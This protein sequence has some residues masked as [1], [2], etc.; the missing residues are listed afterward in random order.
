MDRIE[1]CISFIVGKTAQQVTRRARELLAPFG[2]TPVQY[3]VLKVV[4][5]A[6][7][8]S[9]VDIGKRMVLDSASITGVLDRLESIGLVER[10]PNPGDRRAHLI[11][12][13]KRAKQLM[14]QLDQ[15]MDRLND[16]AAA[17]LKTG[18]EKLFRDLRHLGDDRNWN[19]N[20]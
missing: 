6:E 3:A 11:M 16:E 15:E 17:I 19:R 4:C 1:D 13:T 7:A 12:A 5:D 8:L 9:G 20:V 18:K 14:P 2:V 10:K